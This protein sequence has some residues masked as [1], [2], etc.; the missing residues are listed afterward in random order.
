M[1][2]VLRRLLFFAPIL[3]LLAGCSFVTLV[4]NANGAKRLTD[5]AKAIRNSSPEPPDVPRELEK[6][7]TLPYIVEPA[8]VL[9]VQPANLESDLRLPGDQ[10]VLPDGT[11]KLGRYGLLMAAGKTIPQ[12]EA[13]A[14]RQIQSQIKDPVVITV[15][16]VSRQS[17]YYYVLGEVNAPG[18]YAYQGYETVLQGLMTAGG[19]NDR[20]SRR[21]I[22][23]ARPTLPSSCRK[24]LPVCYE[25]MVQ[26]GD[27]STNY[28]L[29]P[30]DRIYVPGRNCRDDGRRAKKKD[31]GVCDRPQFGCPSLPGQPQVPLGG[32]WSAGDDHPALGL[33]LPASKSAPLL[34]GP[35]Q[36][37][38]ELEMTPP[39]R[40][41]PR[42]G[43]GL[44]EE[45]KSEQGGA[46]II[47]G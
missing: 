40:S 19:L 29:S 44:I 8:D 42:N 43:P 10:P 37:P 11:I 6:R 30:G 13:E 31:C 4:T 33:P 9:L 14:Q 41:V 3:L 39:A 1:P 34:P 46:R 35:P 15:R 24:V 22:I 5:E 21:N 2:P 47:S 23:L 12:I 25:D 17:K 27:T 32:G 36:A 45:S 20:A 18:A 26:L 28:Q 7:V 38:A 16:L